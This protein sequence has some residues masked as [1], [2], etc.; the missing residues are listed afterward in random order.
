MYKIRKKKEKQ[1]VRDNLITIANNGPILV[2]TNYWESAL[3]HA[4]LF[5]LTWNA[6]EARLLTPDSQ[7]HNL[8]DMSTAKNIILS[9]GPWAQINGEVGI[10]I[11]FEDHS[12]E[13]F[14]LYM[15]LICMDWCLSQSDHGES[16]RFSVWTREG[17][18]LS[19]PAR[20][21][22]VPEIP[23]LREW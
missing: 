18:Q 4:G 23:Y 21:R 15:E 12:D 3:A 5:F 20:F 8:S 11:L 10:E 2:H 13:P 6:G 19:L 7:L 9:R 16:F 22:V 1:G 14:A 17:I